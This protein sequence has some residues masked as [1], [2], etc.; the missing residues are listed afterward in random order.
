MSTAYKS[1]QSQGAR[2]PVSLSQAGQAVT[3]RAPVALTGVLVL[4][5][6]FQMIKL[7]ANTVLEDLFLDLDSVDSNAGPTAVLQVGIANAAGTG[8]TGPVL[9][10]TTGAQ[11]KSGGLFRPTGVDTPRLTAKPYDR[12]L[13]V[14]AQTGPATGVAPTASG[15]LKGNWQPS[16][17]YQTG[18]TITLPNG[19]MLKV[20]GGGGSVSSPQASQ[21]EWNTTTGQT[22]ADNGLTWTCISVVVALGARYRNQVFGA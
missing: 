20:T 19:S 15:T 5:D 3:V 8:I 4:N 16:T 18:D 21:P 22:T 11:S 2:P 7:P 9:L 13:L 17:A 12:F 10:A 14:L 6:T 1:A